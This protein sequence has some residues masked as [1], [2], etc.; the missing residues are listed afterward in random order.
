MQQILEAD[1]LPQRVQLKE[2]LTTCNILDSIVKYQDVW[3]PVSVSGIITN[4]TATGLLENIEPVYS[5]S[6]LKREI[7]TDV[8]FHF[9]ILSTH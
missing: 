5:E 2:G 7:Q 8:D 3:R 9:V 1:I 4:V 6:Q